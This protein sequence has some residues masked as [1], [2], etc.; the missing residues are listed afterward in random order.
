MIAMH[1]FLPSKQIEIPPPNDGKNVSA[2]DLFA[3]LYL[4]SRWIQTIPL[5]HHS[6]QAEREVVYVLFDDIAFAMAMYSMIQGQKIICK[7]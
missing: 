4:I 1:A 3:L 2:Q 6:K 5:V 7:P